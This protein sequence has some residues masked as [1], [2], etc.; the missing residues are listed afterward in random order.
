[1]VTGAGASLT[2]RVRLSQPGEEGR[3]G[4]RG[5][6]AGWVPLSRTVVYSGGACMGG[7]RSSL[8]LVGVPTSVGCGGSFAWSV[9]HD[10][11]KERRGRE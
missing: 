11:R 1:M 7:V 9:G 10:R 5:E 3:E 8:G 4:Q 6:I 2:G